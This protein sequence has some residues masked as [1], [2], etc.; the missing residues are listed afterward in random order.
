M[1]AL[2]LILCAVLFVMWFKEH[3]AVLMFSMWIVKKG[4]KEPTDEEMDVCAQELKEMIVDRLTRRK[5][6]RYG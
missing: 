2:T 6:A 4:Y 1:Q 5:G 3:F